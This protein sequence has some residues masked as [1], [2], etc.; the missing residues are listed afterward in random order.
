M[1]KSSL[2]LYTIIIRPSILIL[3]LIIPFVII[4]L[5]SITIFKVNPFIKIEEESNCKDTIV[6]NFLNGTNHIL[7]NKLDKIYQ[8]L[9]RYMIRY[10]ININCDECNNQNKAIIQTDTLIEMIKHFDI[11]SCNFYNLSKTE[12][13]YSKV[14]SNPKCSSQSSINI[15]FYIKNKTIIDPFIYTIIYTIL[16]VISMI[17]SLHYTYNHLICYNLIYIKTN[18]SLI[19]P[20]FEFLFLITKCVEMIYRFIIAINIMSFNFTIFI[21]YIFQFIFIFINSTII[22]YFKLK[23]KKLTQFQVTDFVK[24]IRIIYLVYYIVIISPL[25]ALFIIE[26]SKS[27]K[28]IKLN[29]FIQYYDR[30]F[31]IDYILYTH[32][33]NIYIY[34]FLILRSI[35]MYIFNKINL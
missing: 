3:C 17:S 9:V 35:I 26:S 22:I 23:S 30:T 14:E 27:Y 29:Y 8:N 7:I 2:E 20:I 24:Y 32:L 18:L 33:F 11:D 31:T 4:I 28:Y 19:S 34:S 5:P 21:L 16:L 6:M 1:S 10:E 15:T 13:N 25:I 12:Y